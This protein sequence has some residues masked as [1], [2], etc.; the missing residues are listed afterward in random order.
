[1][2]KQ[3]EIELYK[4]IY[5]IRR[6][7]EQIQK[8]YPENDMKTPMHMSMGA[9]AIAVGVC[10]VLN[11][12]D[13]IFTS[14]RSHA[15]FLAKTMDLEEFFFEMYAKDP[16]TLKGK[17]G[18]MHL[19]LPKKGFMGASAIVS[20]HIPIAVGC[21]W[22]NK[23]N[24]NK[25]IVVIFFGDGAVDEGVFWESLNAACLMKLPILFV[26]EDN[27]FAVHT[28]ISKRHGYAS[29]TDI[30]SKFNCNVLKENTTDI[31]V[32]YE[33]TRKS[34]KLIKTTQMPCFM[35]LKYYRYLEHVGINEDFNAGYRSKDEFE[36]WY[37]KDP[38]NLQRKK[39]LE[40]DYNEAEIQ[41]MER[42]I[43]AQI[44]RSIKLAQ[45]ASFSDR[46]ELYKEIY[47]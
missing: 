20:T 15:G 35:E 36:E 12:E 27:G 14:Y 46:S 28:P 33:L 3:L 6:T 38:V 25:R 8:Y 37:E 11:D 16:S 13:Q 47:S 43:D 45:N 7:E 24:R 34:I 41:K 18:S 40:L 5:L 23:M 21:A 31:E 44:E 22:A 10:H 17:G 9:E 32:I 29:I 19:C 30:I 26:C 2:N 4:K 39:L 1:M 42:G